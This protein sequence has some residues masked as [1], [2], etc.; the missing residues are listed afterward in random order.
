[1]KDKLLHIEGVRGVAC[2]M[3]VLSHLALV[4]Y[5]GVHEKELITNQV[6]SFI[7]NSPL[8][9]FYSGTAAV[10]I[11]FVLSGY[12]LTYGVMKNSDILLAVST[13][14]IRRYF[15]LAIPVV[16]SCVLSFLVIKYSTVDTSKLSAWISSY[17]KF[18]ASLSGSIYSGLLETFFRGGSAYNPVLW[19]MKIEF[20]GSLIIFF[21]CAVASKIERKNQ[22][23]LAF[24]FVIFMLPISQTEKYSYI[25]FMAGTILHNT[26]F[27]INTPFSII[28]VLIG[29][30]F[31]GVHYGSSA[32]AYAISLISYP[33]FGE[34]TNAYYLF[35]A[36]SGILLVTAI[37]KNDMLSNLFSIKPFVY[38]GRV[39]FS[40]YLIHLPIMYLAAPYIFNAT[41]VFFGYFEASLVASL[42][43]TTLIYLASN[44]FYKAFDAK[45]IK[46]S[47][48]ALQLAKPAY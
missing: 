7:F 17:G 18:D 46:L 48:L 27:K 35:C 33:V 30:Y 39:S 32:Y 13:M 38:L 28:M 14:T 4:F 31:G 10:F 25:C 47:K 3:V 8:P 26:R 24:S 44:I 36:F 42:I 29:I 6:E 41:S 43:T 11:F 2:L 12:V 37:I 5:P 1:M 23:A 40:V 16:A 21:Y 34:M 9:F 15:R 45:A 22:I 19:T 20:V